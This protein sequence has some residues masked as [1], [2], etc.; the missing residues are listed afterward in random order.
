MYGDDVHVSIQLKSSVVLNLY[1]C[2]CMNV[3]CLILDH[4]C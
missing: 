3:H 4:K 1:H 2:Q